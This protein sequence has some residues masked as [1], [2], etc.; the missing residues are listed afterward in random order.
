MKIFFSFIAVFAII[1]TLVVPV[2]A[3]FEQFKYGD[4]VFADVNSVW[5]DKEQYPYALILYSIGAKKYELY[6]FPSI[7]YANDTV[8]KYPS[9]GQ[10]YRYVDGAWV[11][12]AGTVQN[13]WK[14][15][16]WDLVWSSFDIY[17]SST[18][19]VIYFE[20]TEPLS[21]FCDGSSCAVSDFDLDGVCDTCGNTLAYS[22]QRTY[23]PNNWP[24]E[25]PLPPLG[26]DDNYH[27]VIMN[28][29]G[30][31]VE[32]ES[33]IYLHTFTPR[34]EYPTLEWDNRANGDF[35]TVTAI[36]DDGL[37]VAYMNYHKYI[38]EN[39]EWVQ[40]E[41]SQSKYTARLGVMGMDDVIYS[42]LNLYTEEGTLFFPVPLWLAVERVAQ[43]EMVEL[44]PMTGQTMMILTVLGVGLLALLILLH[45]FQKGLL[46]R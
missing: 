43:G 24:S 32:D 16:Y 2:F 31:D 15:S 39:G 29:I 13:N 18:S 22:V 7:V 34:Q 1:F 25:L 17:T 10:I 30:Y 6:T 27:Y 38:L 42:T 23:T 28:V 44:I 4:E 19:G 33:G 12:D 20:G 46:I 40:V 26:H 35:L 21:L 5:T 37:N 36:I 45:L 8:M 9:G 11:L 14:K 41:S 3:D